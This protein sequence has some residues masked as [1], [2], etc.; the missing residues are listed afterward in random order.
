M[1]GL[2]MLLTDFNK[3]AHRAAACEAQPIALQW[4]FDFHR[5]LRSGKSI[6]NDINQ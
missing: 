3:L 6:D 2:R 4:A 5:T 1:C